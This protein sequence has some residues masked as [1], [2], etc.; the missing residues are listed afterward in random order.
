MPRSR[1]T[2]TPAFFQRIRRDGALAQALLRLA[3][4][5]EPR[6]PLPHMTTWQLVC[7]EVV[8]TEHPPEHYERVAAE[9]LR[10][11]LSPTELD[12]LRVF[13]WETAGWLN[14]EQ[15]AWDWCSLGEGDIRRVITAQF[16]AGELDAPARDRRLAYLDRYAQPS[17]LARTAAR[18]GLLVTRPMAGTSCSSAQ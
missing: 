9:L 10:R 14:Y 15:M 6:E 3:A 1:T 16:E 2:I 5:Q 11:G 4:A 7:E 13:A 12:D 17:S 8:D 18:P